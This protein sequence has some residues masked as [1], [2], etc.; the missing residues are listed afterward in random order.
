M[1]YSVISLFSGAMGL[2]LGLEQAGLHVVVGQDFEHDCAET[3]RLNNKHIVEG[4][5][6]GITAEQ[7]LSSA[8][9]QRGEA[10]LVC[11]GPPCQ[12]FST[13]GKRLG[14]E[15]PRGSLFKDFVRMIEGIHPRFFLMENVRG[16]VSAKLSQPL[17]NA[18]TVLDVVLEEFASLGYKTIYG[19]LDS[20]NYGAPQFRERLVIV[21]S[22]DN[23]DI[24]L[25]V[26]TNFQQHQC[27]EYRWHT[28][29]DAIK[30]LESNPGACATFS[31]SRAAFLD[32]VPEGGNWRSLPENMQ[33]EAMGGAY[34]S[35]GGKVGFYRRLSYSQPCPTVVTSPVQKSTMLCH[36]KFTRPL[37]VKE[38]ARVQGFPDSW[39][40]AGTVSSQYKQ[41]GNAVPIMLGKAL[42]QMLMS[43]ACQTHTIQTKRSVLKRVKP[44]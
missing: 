8:G 33:S 19:V 11:G 18:T 5:I 24:F 22:R 4:D 23:E 42:G 35:G 31:A 16:L 9:L 10:F 7:M 12:P 37:S 36:P 39:S 32:L 40:F 38:Y 17:P 13:A 2:D 34:A 30:D 15:D 28:L 3:A 20:V 41:I 44:K 21:G 26:P 25:P 1:N 43:V 6:R 29:S 27:L 14:I